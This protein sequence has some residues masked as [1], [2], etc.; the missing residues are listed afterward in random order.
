MPTSMDFYQSVL[1]MP[2]VDSQ[3][4]K[5]LFKEL[6]QARQLAQK[7]VKKASKARRALTLY[8]KNSKES[9]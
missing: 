2:V 4:A 8:D 9:Y 6:K 3:Y 7:C 1:S 5:E